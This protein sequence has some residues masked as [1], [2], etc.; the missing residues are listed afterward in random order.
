MDN[1][2]KCMIRCKA[3][4]YGC[5]YGA[6]RADQGDTLEIDGVGLPAG[7]KKCEWCGKPFKPINQQRFCEAYCQQQAAYA[8]YRKKQEEARKKEENADAHT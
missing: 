2:S 5:H 8:R 7:W 3:E 6:W 4:G 1:L